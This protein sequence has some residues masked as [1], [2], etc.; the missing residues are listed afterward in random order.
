MEESEGGRVAREWG[1]VRGE[2]SERDEKWRK[3]KE[4]EGEVSINISFKFK[5]YVLGLWNLETGEQVANIP[6]NTHTNIL[7][8]QGIFFIRSSFSF[9]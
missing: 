6:P 5:V 8:S 1:S 3:Q 4:S 9:L 2:V 7:R